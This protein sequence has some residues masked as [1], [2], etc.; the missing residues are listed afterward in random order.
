MHSA[1]DSTIGEDSQIGHHVVH[2]AVLRGEIEEAAALAALKEGFDAM[3]PLH[4]PTMSG[5]IRGRV[6]H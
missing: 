3:H 6:K 5:K 2:A 1:I 4:E